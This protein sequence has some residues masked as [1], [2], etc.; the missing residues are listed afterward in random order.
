MDL[1]SVPNRIT[2][3]L[4]RRGRRIRV[5][6]REVIETEVSSSRQPLGARKGKRLHSSREPP[7]E[8][9]HYCPIQNSRSPEF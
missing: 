6:K 1:S 8:G 2:K 5:R 9:Q 3:V 7:E 4:V